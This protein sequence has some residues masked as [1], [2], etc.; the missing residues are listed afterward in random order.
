MLTN[1]TNMNT[2][3]RLLGFTTDDTYLIG[4]NTVKLKQNFASY[5]ST[6]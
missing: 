2:K 4:M 6:M 1:K 5:I 3:Q